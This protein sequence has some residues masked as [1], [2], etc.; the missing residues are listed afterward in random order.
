VK[1]TTFLLLLVCY[2]GIAP[3]QNYP[4]K[5]IRVVTA[6]V[7]GGSDF[8]ARLLAPGLSGALGQ[9]VVVE[10]RGGAGGV[11]AAQTAAKATLDGYTLLLYSGSLYILPLLQEHVPYDAVRDFAPISLLSSAPNILVAHP[12][13]P[14][15]SVRDLLAL[16]KARPGELNYGSGGMASAPHLAAE[17]FKSM[18]RVNIAHILYKGTG[19][20][21]TALVGGEVQLAF[22]SAGTVTPQIKAGKLRGLAVTSLQPS[23]LAPGM[24]TVAASG[25]P[26]YESASVYALFAP[27]G[28]PAAVI[29]RLHAETVRALSRPETKTLFLNAGVE[30]VG[31]SPDELTATIKAEIL[32]WGKVIREAGIR[33]G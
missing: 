3:G 13:L 11:I 1:K 17:L 16:A 22:P 2:P 5:P 10:N 15:K 25:L 14:V 12:S 26:G 9:Q 30:T 23:A 6:G 24:P 33:N 27:A 28:T 18:A 8:V 20:V 32:K 21:L 19:G 7:A 29:S 31:G 4:Y